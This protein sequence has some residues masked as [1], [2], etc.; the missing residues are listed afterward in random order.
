MKWAA[1]STKPSASFSTRE[2]QVPT[3]ALRTNQDPFSSS[4]F[5]GNGL[6]SMLI[7]WGSG[8]DYHLDPPSASASKYLGFYLQDDWK[9]ARRL[10]INLGLRYDFDLPRTERYNRY[11]WFDPTAP[12]PLAGK[13]PGY[14]NLI[15]QMQFTDRNTRSPIDAYYKDFQPRVGLAYELNDKTSIR[16]GYGIFYTVSRATIKGHTGSG[17]STNSTPEWSRDGGITQYAT[18]ANSYP[19]GLNIPPGNTQG[20]A[21]FLGL[22][23]GTETIDSRLQ[24]VH[25]RRVATT[26]GPE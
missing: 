26:P 25:R 17:F 19:D 3:A 2:P 1:S 5:Q 20:T 7:G 15:G 24:Q 11:S 4:S 10:T 13:V 22:G 23:I 6:A 14:P 18:M 9:I 21:T 8:G 16:A 12:S